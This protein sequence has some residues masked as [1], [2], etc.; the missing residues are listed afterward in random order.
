MAK[1]SIEQNHSLPV[2]E[3]KKRLEAL[4]TKLSEKYSIAAKWIGERE[5]ELKRTGV[6]GKILVEDKLVKVVLDLSFALLPLKS[7]I[8][9]RI[10]AELEKNLKDA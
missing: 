10:R 4:S 8:E 6:S 7:K 9:E 5:A 1:L 2:A 3:V